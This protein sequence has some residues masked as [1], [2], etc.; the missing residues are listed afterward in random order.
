MSYFREFPN[1]QYVNRFPNSKSNDE[2]ITAK[3]LFMRAKLR[4][5]FA[6]ILSFSDYYSIIEGERP[7]QIAERVYGDPNYD[8]VIL[9]ANNIININ[10]EWPL[11]NNSFNSYLMEK[12]GSD[13]ALSQIHHYET[14]EIKDSYGRVVLPGGLIVDETFYNAP[15]YQAI[16]DNPPGITFPPIY[17]DP[18]VAIATAFLGTGAN[19][20]KVASVSV[21][22]VGRGY[23]SN[24]KVFF[25]GPPQTVNGSVSVGISSFRVSNIG[26]TSSGQGYRTVPNITFSAPPQS[27]KAVAICTI[28]E[29]GSV[30]EE[31]ITITNNGI[32][33]GLT[34]PSISFS[35]PPVIISGATYRQTSPIP[36]GNI[37]DGMYIRQDGVKV[38]SVSGA[39]SSVKS[40][41]LLTAWDANT[42]SVLTQIDVSTKFSYCTGIEFSPDGTKMY[43][44]GGKSGT[45]LVCRYDLSTAWDLS[46]ATFTNELLVPS[47]GGVRLKSDGTKLYILN[48]DSSYVIKEY[49]LSTPWNI[50]TASFANSYQL[51]S[52]VNDSSIL[53][54]SF[55]S[56]GTKL[57]ATGADND[58]VYE[59]DLLDWDLSTLEFKNSLYIGDRISSA[60]DIFVNPTLDNF[61]ICGGNND[62]LY[63][64]TVRSRTKG[65]GVVNNSSLS[66]ITITMPGVGYTVPPTITISDPYPSV[67]A[68]GT[69]VLSNGQISNVI[70]TNSGFG[71]TTAPTTTIDNVPTFSTATGI[72]SVVD[73]KITSITVINGGDNYDEP[74]TISFDLSPEPTL[75]VEVGDTYSQ[76][77]KTWRWNGTNWEEKVTEG[78]S[79]FDNG[80]LK[81]TIGNLTSIPVSNYEYERRL[82]DEKRFILIPK[83][84][85]LSV[86]ED[87]FRK[88]MK[89]DRNADNVIDSKTKTT[90]N[91]KLSGV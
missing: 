24:T 20:R 25:S 37:I 17:L 28:T 15:E 65:I 40:F 81:S 30:P 79:Y 83:P 11:D 60:S 89:Y 45:F 41:D 44:C 7:E 31:N 70:I 19:S 3:N 21:T 14:L 18:V 57:Y 5:D 22:N 82:N 69:V 27:V 53:G 52:I 90:Y 13:E 77:N 29:S 88:I 9:L 85:Y 91:P 78:F 38:F 6:S 64:Y 56:S 39:G 54:F 50:T 49:N 73:G 1:I 8:W 80:L 23:P 62:V 75:N 2:T 26:I 48:Y 66:S 55:N 47:P 87:D 86:I 16:E 71:Y 35:I 12:Y 36:L 51:G 58:S 32:G 68:Q 61:L 67:T 43:I 4:E 74:P 72:A 76:S 33:Y 63:E 42:L 10:D 34:A 59:F 46:S 84:Q